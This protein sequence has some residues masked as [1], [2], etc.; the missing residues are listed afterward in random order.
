MI[1]MPSIL[2]LFVAALFVIYL[3]GQVPTLT[4]DKVFDKVKDSIVV[5]KALDIQGEAKIQ[6]SGVL[7]PSGKLA[8]N[9]HV[10]TKGI[11]YQVG[12][13]KRFFSATLY[14]EDTDKDICLLDAKGLMGK[15]A[16]IGK[17]TNLKIGETVYA[18]GAPQGL[19]LSLSNGIVAQLRGEPPPMI[20]TTA[21]ISPGS[22]G[23]GL[24]DAEGRLVGLTT[25]YIEG[26]Q[27]LNFAVPV[28]W[29]EEVNSD[30]EQAIA[31]FSQTEWLKRADTLYELKDWHGV[32]DWC[33]K[34]TKSEPNNAAAW[35]G[36]GAAYSNLNQYSD[37][38][39]PLRQA[40]HI[41]RVCGTALLN[42]GLA[43]VNLNR[44][45]DAIDAFQ[46]VIRIKPEV[47]NGWSGLGMAYA[48][49]GNQIAALKVVNELRRLDP[50][51]ADKLSDLIISQQ[52]KN[53][54]VQR[55]VSSHPSIPVS[56]ELSVRNGVVQIGMTRERVLSALGNPDDV[57]KAGDSSGVRE[58]WIYYT[59]L[60]DLDGSD[61]A[62]LTP[63]DIT[64]IYMIAQSKRKAA[65]LFFSKGVLTSFQEQ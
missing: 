40:T 38:I 60:P 15:P 65:Y 39:D 9:C 2:K 59:S 58:V 17:A 64:S 34:W 11:S 45:D 44:Y 28:E 21:A 19:E 10:V 52:S 18:V 12:Q 14:A 35:S 47:V 25:L 27:T 63:A 48:L 49:S 31:G 55:D 30:H 53:S 4:P 33:R 3:P 24:F 57:Q 41:C 54:T 5:V 29:I 42:L 51:L 20:Q 26:G 8:T 43:Y 46:Q 62:G 32:L 1:K 7:L 37:A 56:A 61:L 23:G 16:E 36:I 50:G 22:S 6:G 13:G